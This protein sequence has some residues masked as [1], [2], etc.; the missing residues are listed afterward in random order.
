MLREWALLTA[1]S[2]P[3]ANLKKAADAL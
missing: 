3:K 1:I 2:K